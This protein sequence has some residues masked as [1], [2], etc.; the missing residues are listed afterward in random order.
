MKLLLCG[1]ICPTQK[2]EALFAAGNV[3]AL[4]GGT[5]A[6]FKGNDLNVVNLECALTDGD[7]PIKKIGPNLKSGTTTA[8]FY[9]EDT[10]DSLGSI[11]VP[12]VFT[13]GRCT[14]IISEE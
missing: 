11:G 14:V 2:T 1:D 7:T 6:L 3:E 8:Y 4:F 9:L 13:L 5:A 12:D 10:D